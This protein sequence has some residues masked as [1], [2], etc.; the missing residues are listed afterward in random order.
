MRTR[1]SGLKVF[2]SPVSACF[3]PS[4]SY[5][6]VTEFHEIPQYLYS[7]CSFLL[8]LVPD[9][10]YG[11]SIVYK[12]RDYLLLSVEE[13]QPSKTLKFIF[14]SQRLLGM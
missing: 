3:P 8:K 6:P 13:G 2:K 9:I 14:T 4:P 7:K 12:Q 1:E 11:F 5:I 10:Y